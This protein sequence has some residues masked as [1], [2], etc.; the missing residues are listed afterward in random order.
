MT[1]R[2]TA[3]VSIEAI[4]G[5]VFDR[6]TSLEITNDLTAPAEASLELGDDGSW[7]ELKEYLAIGAS[8]RV[9]ANGRPRM[10]GRIEADDVPVDAANG[11]TVRVLVRTKLSDAA[12]ASADPSIGVQGVTLKAVVLKAYASLGYKEPDFVFRAD[13]SRN[14]MTGKP[15]KGT[16]SKETKLE[17]IKL[18]QARVNPPETIFEFV[19]RHLL[20]HHLSHWDSPDGRIV[21]GAPNDQQSPLYRFVCKRGTQGRANNVLSARRIRDASDSPS[22]V[23]VFGAYSATEF[24]KAKVGRMIEVPEIQAAKLYRPVLFVDHS[25]QTREQADA[26]VRKE[27][28]NRI[29]RLDSWEIRTD[30]WG[31]W[32]GQAETP[33]GVDTVADVD[34]DV[35]GGTTGAYL[36]HRVRLARSAAAGDTTELTMIKRG[37]WQL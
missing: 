19:E 22:I 35:A 6:F 24:Q 13:I 29:K 7:A 5:K 25:I 17:P 4:G 14:L 8:F 3:T 16:Q 10:T 27:I 33:F 12:Y 30:G 36:V 23:G 18:E 1:T 32:D 26:R 28:V 34:V 2:P 31:Y 37:L 21:V 15:S 9:I 20:R 11:A